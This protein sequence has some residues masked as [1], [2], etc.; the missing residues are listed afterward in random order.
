MIELGNK[1][2]DQEL[3]KLF[4]YGGNFVSESNLEPMVSY[5]ETNKN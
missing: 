1:P 2:E 5:L 3:I 4:K